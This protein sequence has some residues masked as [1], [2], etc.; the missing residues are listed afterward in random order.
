MSLS[1]ERQLGQQG[2]HRTTQSPH[3]RSEPQE[4]RLLRARA[5]LAQVEGRQEVTSMAEKLSSDP[6]R[7]RGAFH[8]DGTVEGMA[9]GLALLFEP[10]QFAAVIGVPDVSWEGVE[11]FGVD[12]SRIVVIRNV[13]DQGL[14]VVGSLLEGFSLLVVG[15]VSLPPRAQRALAARARTLG[16]TI[17]TWE[18]WP[19]VTTPL[20]AQQPQFLD[21]PS[22]NP[23]LH[24]RRAVS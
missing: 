20:L 4:E 5:V 7:G 12:V 22:T 14:K 15:E 9:Q 21:H 16:A 10:E 23:L 1:L 3:D 2:R 13:G 6:G 24:Y 18:P 11:G 17:L 8:L 19:T